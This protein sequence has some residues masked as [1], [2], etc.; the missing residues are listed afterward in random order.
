MSLVPQGGNWQDIPEEFRAGG[1]HSNAYRRLD[2]SK[3]SVTIKHAY[4][5]M[6]IHP[7]YDR[8]LSIREVARLQSFPDD[9]IF[10]GN[11]TSQYQQ[12]ANAVPAGLSVALSNSVISYLSKHNLNTD[13]TKNTDDPNN[14]I[15][16]LKNE[17][18]LLKIEIET[19]KKDMEMLKLNNL[20]LNMFD[21]IK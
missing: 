21:S 15:E 4:K 6:I 14:E 3:P 19:I 10:K 7:F 12:L 8:C 1:T 9:Y 16:E 2:A 11:K 17:I 20:Q 13:I 5:S 18:K